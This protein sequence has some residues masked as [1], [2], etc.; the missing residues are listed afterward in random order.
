MQFTSWSIVSYNTIISLFAQPR[1]YGAKTDEFRKNL[2][3]PNVPHKPF[4]LLEDEIQKIKEEL[5]RTKD[6]YPTIDDITFF[7]IESINKCPSRSTVKKILKIKFRDS[8]S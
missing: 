3:E 1:T 6:D 5:E 2:F 4:I 8:R 7:I